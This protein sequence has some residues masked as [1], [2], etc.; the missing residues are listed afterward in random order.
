MKYMWDTHLSFLDTI[1]ENKSSLCDIQESV[2]YFSESP[3]FM[4]SLMSSPQPMV[5]IPEKVISDSLKKLANEE[6]L[7]RKKM[8]KKKR[9]IDD[10]DQFEI[11]DE[12]YNSDT[13]HHVLDSVDYLF[14]SYAQTFKKFSLK[15]QAILKVDMASLFSEAELCEI[16]MNEAN[17]KKS[18]KLDSD[19]VVI[20]DDFEVVGD[21]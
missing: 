20:S 2:K 15:R 16:S 21:D 4:E 5:E 7:K 14:L 18:N 8:L 11:L 6:E 13:S 3:Q 12:T 17:S 10:L 19:K 9:L 1:A